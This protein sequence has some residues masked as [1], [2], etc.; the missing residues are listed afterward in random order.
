MIKN[1]LFL[2]I[3]MFFGCATFTDLRLADKF[4][5]AA[6]SYEAAIS[7]ED[8]EMAANFMSEQNHR[9]EPVLPDKNFLKKIKITSY[10][11]KNLK[12]YNEKSMVE[13]TVE[14]KYYN[15]DY[16]IEKVVDDN[17]IWVYESDSWR[18]TTGLPV[19]E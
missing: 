10:E 14:I 19:F 9:K 13:Q 15:T 16:L 11:V 7:W 18:L 6:E 3:L 2:C 8:F 12:I 1:A 4:E 17:Q 5:K